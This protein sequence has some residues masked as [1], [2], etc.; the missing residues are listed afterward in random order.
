MR[1]HEIMDGLQRWHSD[2]P[3]CPV[4]HFFLFLGEF[5]FL[6]NQPNNDAFFPMAT[7]YLSC[8]GGTKS[9]SHHRSDT[10]VA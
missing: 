7:G 9:L 4:V 2:C 3:S 6:V 10:L 5:P 1:Y 8:V